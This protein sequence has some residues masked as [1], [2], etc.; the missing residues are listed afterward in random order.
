MPVFNYKGV[1]ASGKTASGSVDAES[2]KAA[3]AKLRKQKIF[4][5]KITM[6]GSASRGLAFFQSVKIQEISAMTRQLAVLLGA[7]IPLID[8]LT[9]TMDQVENPML[10]KALSEIK[11]KVSEGGKLAEV[12][13]A[14]PKLFSNIYIQMVRAGEASGALD[15][16]FARL[17]DYT[18]SQAELKSKIKSAMNYPIIMIVVSSLI[19]GYIFTGVIPKITAIFTKQKMV[20][21]MATQ[22]VM[23]ITD[24][25]TGYWWLV[26]ILIG[27]AVFGF[28]SYSKTPN[29]RRKIDDFKLKGP[30]IGALSTKIAV[31]RFSRTMSTL[32]S[33][34][35][36]LLPALDIV[37]N[38][39]DNVVLEKIIEDAMVNVKEGEAISEPLKRSGRFPNMFIHMM[40]VGEK[41]GLMEPMLEKV[42]NIYDGEVDEAINGM[43]SIMTPIMIVM[44][45]GTIMFI[46]FA[47]LM[48]ILQL[49]SGGA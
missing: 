38:V 14:Y 15:T 12:M 27:L 23:G 30:I 42:A 3:R 41:T 5:T 39:V 25:I 4:P 36:Q 7:N 16:V 35:V 34:G 2:E 44:M 33:S 19:L 6:Q 21:P 1:D 46:V 37:K 49:S 10:R 24:I 31:S 11:D 48:P 26:L 18:E 40:T 43:T 32:L 17:A 29:G 28:V 9:A 13:P 8:T 45:G 20:L 22:I 47:V